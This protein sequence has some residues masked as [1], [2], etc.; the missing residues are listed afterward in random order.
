MCV[1]A[2]CVGGSTC[3][4]MCMCVSVCVC[5]HLWLSSDDRWVIWPHRH[6]QHHPP[7][8]PH[9]N[10]IRPVIYGQI[11][12]CK[13]IISLWKQ[14]LGDIHQPWSSSVWGSLHHMW[15]CGSPAT[16]R[17][18]IWTNIWWSLPCFLSVR[19]SEHFRISHLLVRSKVNDLNTETVEEQTITDRRDRLR[20]LLPNFR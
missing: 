1:F 13:R 15:A 14:A 5:M 17:E 18:V 4:H 9:I 11:T 19:N 20:P 16:V 3:I 8:M 7:P 10:Y 6:Q 2:L 12:E